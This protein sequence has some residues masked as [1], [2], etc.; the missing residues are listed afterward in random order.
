[1]W[2]STYFL[3]NELEEDN[4]CSIKAYPSDKSPLSIFNETLEGVARSH[5]GPFTVCLKSPRKANSMNFSS[6][7]SLKKIEKKTPAILRY[8]LP[9]P[10]KVKRHSNRRLFENEKQCFEFNEREGDKDRSHRSIVLRV[11]HDEQ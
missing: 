5:C 4:M 11:W 1:M 2:M 8:V 3:F 7:R 6:L 10:V 9:V